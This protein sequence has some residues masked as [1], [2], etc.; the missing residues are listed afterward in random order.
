[1][2]ASFSSGFPGGCVT[3]RCAAGAT[4]AILISMTG[5]GPGSRIHALQEC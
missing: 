3:L 1:M 4:A 2:P 5:S